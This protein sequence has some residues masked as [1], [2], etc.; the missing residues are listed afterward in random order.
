MNTELSLISLTSVHEHLFIF[1][2]LEYLLKIIYPV[3][4]SFLFMIFPR[5]MQKYRSSFQKFS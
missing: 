3:K 5:E 1:I 4:N 2:I